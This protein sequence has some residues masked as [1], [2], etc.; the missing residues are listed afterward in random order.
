[1]YVGSISVSEKAQDKE[2]TISESL[3][4][5]FSLAC[6][7]LHFKFTRESNLL[8]T[9]VGSFENEKRKYSYPF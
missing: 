9:C 5:V 4:D 1:M 6:S 2:Y 7:M 8:S 3:Y